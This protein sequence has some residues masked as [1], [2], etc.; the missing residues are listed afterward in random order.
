MIVGKGNYVFDDGKTKQ[1]ATAG[2][3][4]VKYNQPSWAIEVEHQR[5]TMTNPTFGQINLLF[6]PHCLTRAFYLMDFSLSP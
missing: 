4:Q 6:F 5:K 1:N 3:K 2:K